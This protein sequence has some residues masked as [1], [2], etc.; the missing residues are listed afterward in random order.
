MPVNRLSVTVNLFIVL[1]LV[2]S[3]P[4]A[5]ASED[6]DPSPGNGGMWAYG[7]MQ[8]G[9]GGLSANESKAI[10]GSG[11]WDEGSTDLVYESEPLSG[12]AQLEGDT[13]H[14]RLHLERTC[15]SPLSSCNSVEVRL[16][17]NG[18]IVSEAQLTAG[19]NGVY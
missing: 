8:N 3:L 2:A 14:V 6:D 4:L 9:D 7:T 15:P 12:A 13:V 5:S 16:Y 17:V 18:T 11:N 10:G 19:G 1:L